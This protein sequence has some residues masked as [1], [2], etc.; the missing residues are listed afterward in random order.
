MEGCKEGKGDGREQADL[1]APQTSLFPRP[2]CLR[3]GS[4]P[5]S[6]IPSRRAEG[7]PRGCALDHPARPRAPG[8]LGAG[9]GAPRAQLGQRSGRPP[10]RQVRI[11][12][13]AS[14]RPETTRSRGGREAVRSPAARL[15]GALLR[16]ARP[17]EGRC[18]RARARERAP[19]PPRGRAGGT[20]AA[21]VVG[22]TGRWGGP[23]LVRGGAAAGGRSEGD[24]GAVCP[25]SGRGRVC[26][27][28]GLSGGEGREGRG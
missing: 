23:G 22:G 11:D 26:P 14:Q 2:H 21:E 3:L 7:R 17:L 28:A 19:G 5:P 25:G 24:G 16:G 15:S 20:A 4:L 12:P 10:K 8:A 9:T 13:R 6:S 27:R 18:P 1:L